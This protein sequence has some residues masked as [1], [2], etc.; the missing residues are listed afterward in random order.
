MTEQQTILAIYSLYQNLPSSIRL[1]IKKMIDESLTNTPAIQSTSFPW[2][3]FHFTK[4]KTK[5]YGN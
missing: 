4:H 1:E 2:L 5:K 3:G